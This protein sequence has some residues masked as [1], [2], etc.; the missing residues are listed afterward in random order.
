MFDAPSLLTRDLATLAA[1]ASALLDGA[2][3]GA[4]TGLIIAPELWALVPPEVRA[5]FAPALTKL[6]NMLPYSDTQLLGP[7]S[8]HVA[9]FTAAQGVNVWEEHGAW[10]T[11][12]DPGFGPHVTARI[13]AAAASDPA[14]RAP[15]RTRAAAVRQAIRDALGDRVAVF[16]S[17]P[18]PA[19]PRG[20]STDPAARQNILALTTLA[21]LG[22]LPAVSLPLGTVDGRPI[23]LSLLGPDGSDE[24]LLALAATLLP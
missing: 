11:E 9:V 12:Q 19:L 10:I 2:A 15:R 23:G 1:G 17:T 22:G 5:T 20:T 8:D 18:E 14:D 13:R 6:R 16:P 3:T 4:P 7:D 24:Q 21:P